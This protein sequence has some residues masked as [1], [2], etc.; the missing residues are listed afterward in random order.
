MTQDIFCSTFPNIRLD[1][2]R[3]A[4]WPT[5]NGEYEI[6]YLKK[7]ELS[8]GCYSLSY[9]SWDLNNAIQFIQNTGYKITEFVNY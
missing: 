4:Y 8:D 7:I 3:M 5:E 9:N 2:E 1:K 6:T